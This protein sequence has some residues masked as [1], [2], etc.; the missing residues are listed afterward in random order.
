MSDTKKII[1]QKA[2]H[3]F[4]QKT[5]QEVSLQEIVQSVGLTKGAFY[6]YFKSKDEVF[7]ECTRY[8]FDY[9]L[10]TDFSDFPK[11]SLKAFYKAYIYKLGEMKTDAEESVK[12]NLLMFFVEA[13]RRIPSFQAI[14]FLQRKKE[15]SAWME[16]VE[17]AKDIKEI[18]SDLDSLDIAQMFLNISDGIAMS[19]LMPRK[20]N[21]RYTTNISRDWDNLYSLLGGK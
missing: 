15:Q 2:L 14:Y 1:L 21:S 18:N 19:M 3:L 8:F 13:S 9:Y 10:I 16:M 17:R 11:A 7:E 5:Y 12:T 4:L 20:E 6:H